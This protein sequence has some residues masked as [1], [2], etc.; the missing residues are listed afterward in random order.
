[1]QKCFGSLSN[2]QTQ[3]DETGDR[4]QFPQLC[5]LASHLDAAGLGGYHECAEML[6]QTQDK[7]EQYLKLINA[8]V[9]IFHKNERRDSAK[10]EKFLKRIRRGAK[11]L[12]EVYCTDH[13][14]PETE[15]FSLAQHP[16]YGMK[17]FADRVYDVLERHWRCSCPQRAARPSTGREARLSLIRHRQLAPKIKNGAK[18][19][20]LQP[21]AKFEILLPVCKDSVEWK[22]TNVEIRN[23]A[24]DILGISEDSS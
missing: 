17:E 1:M 16:S 3:T 21:S 2:T 15:G 6:G 20:G 11:H 23:P 14:G 7:R 13:S 18:G 24:Y 22:V 4:T 12:M 19:G 9:S 10:R 5:A 8:D